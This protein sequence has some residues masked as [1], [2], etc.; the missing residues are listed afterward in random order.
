[1][2]VKTYCDSQ[3]EHGKSNTDEVH[4]S[5]INPHIVIVDKFLDR[6]DPIQP[7]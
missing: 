7:S 5:P 4:F 3:Q 1:M 6:R 2:I